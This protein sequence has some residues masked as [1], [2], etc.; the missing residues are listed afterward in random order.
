M[1]I[2][3]IK[4]R[5]TKFHS[6]NFHRSYGIQ[7]WLCSKGL[8]INENANHKVNDTMYF[9]LLSEFYIKNNPEK[10]KTNLKECEIYVQNNFQKFCHFAIN[11]KL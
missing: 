9:D 10:I 8:C 3:N 1:A 4:T 7:K 5:S 11:K 2:I 6:D